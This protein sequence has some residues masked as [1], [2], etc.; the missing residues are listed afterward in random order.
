MSLGRFRTDSLYCA[1]FFSIKRHVIRVPM[2]VPGL[3]YTYET[4]VECISDLG[5]ADQIR[6]LVMRDQF[7][8]NVL[9]YNR[10]YHKEEEHKT[11]K[12]K[13]AK[14][15]ELCKSAKPIISAII[16]MPVAEAV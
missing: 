7:P 12:S 15:A 11:S 10:V 16:N 9:N 6:V 13:V 8:P 2:L 4:L 1:C 14:E 5:I 3:E